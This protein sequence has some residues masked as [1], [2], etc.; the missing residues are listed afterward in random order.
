VAMLCAEL[1]VMR[2]GVIVEELTAAAL[3]Q[4]RPTHP[5]TQQLLK[6]SRGYD[7]RAISE[8]SL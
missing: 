3:R 8:A 2:E 1:A 4:G 6:A 5:Y 7:P